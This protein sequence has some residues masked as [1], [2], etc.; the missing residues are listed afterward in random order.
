M[1]KNEYKEYYERLKLAVAVGAMPVRWFPIKPDI[2]LQEPL[3]SYYND[4][5]NF[6]IAAAGRQ[7]L[8]TEIQKRNL[9]VEA[10]SKPNASYL[11]L[12]PVIAQVKKIYW[13]DRLS[14]VDLFPSYV[15]DKVSD[16]E[17]RIKLKNGTVIQCGSVDTIQRYEGVS[18]DGVLLDEAGDISNLKFVIQGN[19]GPMLVARG[20]WLHVIGVPKQSLSAEYKEL[21]NEYKDGGHAYTWSTDMVQSPGTIAHLKATIDPL[22]YSEMYQGKFHEGYGGLAYCQFNEKD[23]IK[24]YLTVNESLP[25]FCTLDFNTSIMPINIG[26]VVNADTRDAF[27]NILDQSVERHTNIYKSIPALKAKLIELNGG[28]VTLARQKKTLCYG[29]STANNGTVGTRGSLWDEVKA[30]FRDGPEGAWDVEIRTKTNPP[31]DRRISATNARLRT[32]DGRT[33]TAISS[34][35]TE[36]IRDFKM[37]SSA[38]LSRSKEKLEKQERSHA[39]DAFGYFCYYHFPVTSGAMYNL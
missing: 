27:I 37:V 38:D 32:A 33:H 36:L 20:G 5:S 29:D 28:N 11:I 26:Q 30:L 8:K 3:W 21:W 35:A 15:V 31:L 9:A 7:S 12:A 10:L 16:S 23:H 18:L 17:L 4:H 14:V 19:I 6:L 24:D 34:K 13:L 39:S 22:T 2:L 1:T 25:L